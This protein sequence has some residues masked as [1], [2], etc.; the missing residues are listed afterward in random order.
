MEHQDDLPIVRLLAASYA[1]PVEET[2]RD[3]AKSRP[4]MPRECTHVQDGAVG[5]TCREVRS[6]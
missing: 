3:T 1:L 4:G 6:L 5:F 2:L